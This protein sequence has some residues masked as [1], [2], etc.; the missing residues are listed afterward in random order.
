MVKFVL[1][2][3][4][5]VHLSGTD[6]TRRYSAAVTS[7]AT[8]VKWSFATSFK[9]HSRRRFQ[10]NVS[11]SGSEGKIYHKTSFISKFFAINFLLNV[12]NEL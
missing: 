1:S 12:F 5:E 6:N 11:A 3:F 7:A 2:G 8:V 10:M 4:N 9:S